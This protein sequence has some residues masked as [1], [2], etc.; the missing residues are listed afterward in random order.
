ME[1]A[2]VRGSDAARTR[3]VNMRSRS[4]V[5]LVVGQDVCEDG[6]DA[7]GKRAS[8]GGGGAAAGERARGVVLTRIT[9]QRCL[10]A[11][12]LLRRMFETDLRVRV[13]RFGRVPVGTPRELDEWCLRAA[14]LYQRERSRGRPPCRWWDRADPPRVAAMR[15][16]ADYLGL[17]A[18]RAECDALLSLLEPS[19]ARVAVMARSVAGDRGPL[20]VTRG[21]SSAPGSTTNTTSTTTTTTT[22]ADAALRVHLGGDGTLRLR[23]TARLYAVRPRVP[24]AH[25]EFWRRWAAQPRWGASFTVALARARAVGGGGVGGPAVVVLTDPG[26]H[27]GENGGAA[28]ASGDPITLVCVD[29]EE[30]CDELCVASVP[31]FSAAAGD[32]VAPGAAW[33]L[34]PG[35]PALPDGALGPRLSGLFAA[36]FSRTRGLGFERS[37]A[38]DAWAAEC[39]RWLL[40]HGSGTGTGA[41][42]SD[43]LA[44]L[45]AYGADRP[46]GALWALRAYPP[47]LSWRRDYAPALANA[48]WECSRRGRLPTGYS[49]DYVCVDDDGDGGGDDGKDDGDASRGWPVRVTLCALLLDAQGCFSTWR[50]DERIGGLSVPTLLAHVLRPVLRVTFPACPATAD[51][52]SLDAASPDDAWLDV[53]SLA[54][55]V[56]GVLTLLP[57]ELVTNRVAPSLLPHGTNDAYWAARLRSRTAADAEAERNALACLTPEMLAYVRTALPAATAAAAPRLMPVHRPPTVHVL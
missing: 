19:R 5:T 3:L 55:A 7:H 21:S 24:S 20:T 2:A 38:D 49:Q 41:A 10:P 13:D 54:D 51:A 26:G 52:A 11:T 35:A 37:A 33:H 39:A 28:T 6:G 56:L 23:V 31:G 36:L 29:G 17:E 45:D 27:P 34:G 14:L 32:C 4:R 22:L 9:A 46:L 15:A 50:Y 47:L 43:P 1:R 42:A 53:T 8:G 16:A 25:V 18:L 40:D 30:G 44:A 12:C 57:P 48:L